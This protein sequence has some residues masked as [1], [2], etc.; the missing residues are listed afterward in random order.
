MDCVH[1]RSSAIAAAAFAF[2]LLFWHSSM[3]Y[4]DERFSP[5]GVAMH[6]DVAQM[7]MG[8]LTV[9]GAGTNSHALIY[10]PAELRKRDFSL[11][12]IPIGLGL[13]NDA[14]EVIGFIDDHKYEFE[15]FEELDAA[16]QAR[17]I[18]ESQKFDNKWV[19]ALITPYI[20]F[21]L[22]GFGIVYYSVLHADSKVDQ[23][24]FFPAVGL[25][26]YQDNVLGI[27]Y[28]QPVHMFDQ[29]YDVGFA[30]RFTERKTFAPL[31]ISADD[32]NKI[33]EV[34]KSAYDEFSVSHRGFGFDIGASRSFPMNYE[35]NSSLEVG[36]AVQ[37]LIGKLDHYIKPNVNIGLTY[38]NPFPGLSSNSVLGAEITDFFNRRGGGLSLRLNAGAQFS[39]VSNAV[40][41]RFG[42]H[43]GYPTVGF[44]L[45]FRVVKI[46]YAYFTRELGIRA[47]QFGESTHRLQLSFN[48]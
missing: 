32:A 46:D 4:A 13:D 18:T 19:N 45:D 11:D 17:F 36:V 2:I 20:G 12:I 27:G 8:G 30:L 3:I 15:H 6:L 44:G 14:L 10:N 35:R 40:N 38:R 33:E 1:N 21:S 34:I 5:T 24:I 48:Y 7:G 41:F 22:N 31:R 25:R 16:S 42:F 37:D 26:G 47:G 28:G 29:D 9:A 39:M 23:G 43:Q